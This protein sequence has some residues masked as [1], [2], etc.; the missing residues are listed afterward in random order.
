MDEKEIFSKAKHESL[1]K[2]LKEVCDDF[3]FVNKTDSVVS[4]SMK[5][6]PDTLLALCRHLCNSLRESLEERYP[7]DLAKKMMEHVL[8]TDEEV[9]DRAE[10]ARKEIPQYL[11]KLMGLLNEMGKEVSDDSTDEA[12]GEEE[13]DSEE[14]T[15][16]S[17]GIDPD[18]RIRLDHF[19]HNLHDDNE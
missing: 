11:K 13:D 8:L 6:S 12:D 17:D 5:G 16:K 7:K 18:V 4:I 19:L 1:D 2:L 10:E 3:M 9:K 15:D 14:E